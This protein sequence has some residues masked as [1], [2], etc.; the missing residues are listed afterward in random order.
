MNSPM[1]ARD[2]YLRR[3]RQTGEVVVTEHRVWDAQRFI[4]SQSD[5]ANDE[6][7]RDGVIPVEITVTTREDYRAQAGANA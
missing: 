5:L 1:V 4:V 6:A 3:T 7:S 2:L